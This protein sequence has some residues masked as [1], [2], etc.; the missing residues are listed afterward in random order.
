MLVMDYYVG[1]HD[2]GLSL[3]FSMSAI[4]NIFLY[5]FMLE[6][7][8]TGRKAGGLTFKIFA[9]VEA[10]IAVL[11]PIFGPYPTPIS[12]AIRLFVPLLFVHL[13]FAIALYVTLFMATT[14][15][16][17]STSDEVAKRGFSF[18]RMASVSIMAAYFFF[19]MDNLWTAL[20]EPEGYT[21][22]VLVAWVAAGIAGV[23]LY[24]GFVLPMRTKKRTK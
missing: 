6:I 17:K 12:T 15:S 18:I 19:V 2:L 8:Y 24:V 1:I 22:W 20:Y 3:A 4:A 21:Y 13:V 14:R 7:F 5:L 23:L 10:S 16:I 9:T 11:L